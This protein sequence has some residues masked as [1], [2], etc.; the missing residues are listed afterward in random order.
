MPA[1]AVKRK[2][3][4]LFGLIGRKVYVSG[5][6][7]NDLNLKFIFKSII[8]FISLSV[9]KDYGILSVIVKYIDI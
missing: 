1:A 5:K 9:R 6:L 2:G 8:K 7:T 4:V 3:L